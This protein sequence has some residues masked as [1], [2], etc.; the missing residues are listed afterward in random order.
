MKT[1]TLTLITICALIAWTNALAFERL[2]TGIGSEGVAINSRTQIAVVASK[3]Y[4]ELGKKPVDTGTLSIIDLKTKQIINTIEVGGVPVGP[5]IN[6][7]TNTVVFSDKA[8]NEVVILDLTSGTET[9]R[10][11]VGE[12]P[13][14]VGVDS[15][16]N[17]A[18]V[19]ST[20]DSKL[21][22]IDLVSA[23]I[24][25]TIEVGANPVCMHWSINPKD[26][27]AIV[28]NMGADTLTVM[29]IE[30]GSVL[31]TIPV[32]Q[33]PGPGQS[34]NP[35]TNTAVVP[36]MNNNMMEI[37]D[38]NSGTVT[39]TVPVGAAPVC[40]V[41]DGENNI[42]FISNYGDG[43]VSAIDID[44]G[45][46]ISTI[47]GV[48][49]GPNCMAIDATQNLLLVTNHGGDTALIEL[50]DIL[51]AIPDFS[52]T[53]FLTLEK[54]LNM[55]SLPLKPVMP[56][57]AQG[58]MSEMGATTVIKYDT[59]GR[60]FVGLTAADSGRDFAIEGGQGY[61]VNVMQS[62]IVPF[63]GAAWTNEPP[64]AAAPPTEFRSSSWAFVVSGD[65]TDHQ[66]GDCTVTVRNLRTGAVSTDST[67]TGRFSAVFADLNRN[68]VVKAG[69]K[70][71]IVIKDSTGRIVSGPIVRHID[72]LDVRKAFTD[73][74]VRFG[75]VIP[76][77]SVLLQ[78]YPNP[79]N[80]ETW[81]PYEL[82]TALPVTVSIYN[83][84][85][86]RVRTLVLGNKDAGIYA[87]RDRAVYWDGRNEAGEFVASGVY[88][89]TLQAGEE[90]RATRKMVILK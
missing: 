24:K 80:P 36:F 44:T 9:A 14:C 49:E 25:H 67:A 45:T 68:P 51:G 13:S 87:S 74:L 42:A 11:A 62:K 34:L 55:I 88:F 59:E 72:E 75:H 16:L 79:F 31:R 12:N 40:S 70:V 43:S 22:V 27:T 69:D 35:E 21:Y 63:V 78:N 65:L 84:D 52:N 66:G 47:D 18:V 64:V 54:G 50:D 33:G 58:L 46:L 53:F 37:V 82:T 76:K 4:A 32:G 81:I 57:T 86:Q 5:A 90:F 89:Y 30:N 29:D 7:N 17:L 3:S 23:S 61:I 41:I 26:M 71:E 8:H 19:A 73:V 85:G 60:R 38:I 39:H 2:P 77:K 48:G 15:E 1:I 6:E 28:A 20:A 56:I 83:T 10:I